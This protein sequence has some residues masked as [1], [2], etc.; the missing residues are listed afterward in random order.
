MHKR[1]LRISHEKIEKSGNE[2]G[3][4]KGIPGISR[5]VSISY[6]LIRLRRHVESGLSA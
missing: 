4:E 3:E 1:S 2:I 6:D 5:E